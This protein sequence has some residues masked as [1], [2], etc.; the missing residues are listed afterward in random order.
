MSNWTSFP[1]PSGIA[2]LLDNRSRESSIWCTR[3]SYV[4]AISEI[5]DLFGEE[6][7]GN[8]AVAVV[9]VV[10][11]L[12][13][14]ARPLETPSAAAPDEAEAERGDEAAGNDVDGAELKGPLDLA[15][16]GVEPVA[17][18]REFK[19]RVGEGAANGVRPER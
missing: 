6:V 3:S 7:E 11:C 15:E 18:P 5:C 12:E 16:K 14:T 8:E 10:S 9:S 13:A 19:S 1:H 4:R 17:K 2:F